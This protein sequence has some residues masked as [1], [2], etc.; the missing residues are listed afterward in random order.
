MTLSPIVF[1]MLLLII[2]TLV[3][4]LLIIV[5]ERRTKFGNKDQS[6]L[7]MIKGNIGIMSL[8]GSVLSLIIC[9]IVWIILLFYHFPTIYTVNPKDNV[10]KEYVIWRG[11]IHSQYE[12]N[13]FYLRNHTSEPLAEVSFSYGPSYIAA[14][15]PIKLINIIEPNHTIELS[16]D[17]I[18]VMSEPPKYISVKKDMLSTRQDIEQRICIIPEAEYRKAMEDLRRIEDYSIRDFL[19]KRKK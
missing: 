9:G 6:L 4:V 5:S 1:W 12:Y 16:C 7:D 3:W 17:P 11:R 8:A 10:S 13:K 2:P 14:D 18:S 19:L 15:D